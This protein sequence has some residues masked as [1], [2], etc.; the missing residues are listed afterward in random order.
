MRSFARTTA[1]VRAGPIPTYPTSTLKRPGTCAPS[2]LCLPA[3]ARQ[4]PTPPITRIALCLP[5]T[6]LIQSSH[7]L[8]HIASSM[9]VLL[10]LPSTKHSP[11]RRL[12]TARHFIR[13]P[14]NRT[15]SRSAMLTLTARARD[16]SAILLRVDIHPELATSITQLRTVLPTWHTGLIRSISSTTNLAH[17]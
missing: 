11:E 13:C 5:W 8:V 3:A 17:N 1:S 7:L 12:V 16:M 14:L 2:T 10:V 4:P 6:R 9:D 15:A